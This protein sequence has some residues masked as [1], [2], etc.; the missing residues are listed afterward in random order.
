MTQ[1]IETRHGVCL[2]NGQR[3]PVTAIRCAGYS[4]SGAALDASSLGLALRQEPCRPPHLQRFGSAGF[5]PFIY[6]VEV[7]IP[8]VWQ[9]AMTT[10]EPVWIDYPTSYPAYSTCSYRQH[11]S[12]AD[13][14]SKNRRLLIF[15]KTPTKN[16]IPRRGCY[17]IAVKCFFLNCGSFRGNR[18]ISVYHYV[19]L[20]LCGGI[21]ADFRT[22]RHRGRVQS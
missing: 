10:N 20:L 15:T 7:H 22:N 3:C 6:T 2:A 5:S 11:Q 21:A 14:P 13:A 1:W 16:E 18:A 8:I 17:R 9:S 4:R 12:I 19:I